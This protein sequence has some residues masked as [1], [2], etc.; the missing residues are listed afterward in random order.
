MASTLAPTFPSPTPKQRSK[1]VCLTD[2]GCT[3]ALTGA[4]ELLLPKFQAIFSWASQPFCFLLYED[5]LRLLRIPWT[6]K[7]SIYFLSFQ[8]N[9]SPGLL[10]KLQP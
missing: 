7:I 3:E 1:H 6:F 2:S 10:T 8:V 5:Y 9:L 4:G